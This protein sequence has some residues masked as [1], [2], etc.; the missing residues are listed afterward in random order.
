[1]KK[2]NKHWRVEFLTLNNVW[3]IL[4]F[5]LP[6]E[7]REMA[8]RKHREICE[9]IIENGHGRWPE[10]GESFFNKKVGETS[11]EN[12]TMNRI[13]ETE[14]E[15]TM[16]VKTPYRLIVQVCEYNYPLD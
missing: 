16:Y 14:F 7:S 8:I 2:Q 10:C 13:L 9:Q 3:A 5:S 6:F 11:Y 1:M 15:I 12:D 4:P